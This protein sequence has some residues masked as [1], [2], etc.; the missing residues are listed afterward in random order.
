[1]SDRRGLESKGLTSG[2]EKNC[3]NNSYFI[4]I[5]SILI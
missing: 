3:D 5:Y 1:M 4:K 2:L